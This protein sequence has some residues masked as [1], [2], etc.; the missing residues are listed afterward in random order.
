MPILDENK[1]GKRSFSNRSEWNESTKDKVNLQ[2]AG[3][4]SIP[5]D[6]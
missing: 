3:F 5:A 2:S 4:S 6:C 1:G